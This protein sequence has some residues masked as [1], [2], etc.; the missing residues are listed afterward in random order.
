MGAFQMKALTFQTSAALLLCSVSWAQSP[1]SQATKPVKP[2]SEKS[3]P[4]TEA[5]A[6][7]QQLRIAR[8]K[9]LRRGL[10]DPS[11]RLRP[12]LFMQGLEQMKRMKVVSHIGP[13]SEESP[14]KK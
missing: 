5:W 11:G 3:S 13:V 4:T 14:N 6:T 8:Q 7:E 10:S 9:E 12:D 2:T 1:T